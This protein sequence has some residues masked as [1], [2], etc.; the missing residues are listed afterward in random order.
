MAQAVRTGYKRK[1]KKAVEV[2]R[3]FSIYVNPHADEYTDPAQLQRRAF[4]A[5]EQ[6]HEDGTLKDFILRAVCHFID[7]YQDAGRP[8]SEQWQIEQAHLIAQHL[9]P[10]LK[11]LQPPVVY[12]VSPVTTLSQYSRP[13]DQPL[14]NEEEDFLEQ[15]LRFE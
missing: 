4:A 6:A 13:P 1:R 11:K 5:L 12:G 15:H 14:D 8:A 7:D 2:S 3:I 9:I 10:H